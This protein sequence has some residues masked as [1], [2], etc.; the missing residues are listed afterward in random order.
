MNIKIEAGANVQITDKPIVNINGDL[1]YNEINIYSEANKQDA[2][3]MTS[4]EVKDVDEYGKQ[5]PPVVT[6]TP[7]EVF[8]AQVKRIMLLAEKKNDQKMVL[9]ARGNGG[10]YTFKVDGQGFCKVMDLLIKDY[11]P[12]IYEYLSGANAE[13]AGSIK[14][15]C[16]FIGFVLDTHLY[17]EPKL[18]KSDLKSV[19]EEVYGKGTS[20]TSKLST[21][22]DTNEAQNLFGIVKEIMKNAKKA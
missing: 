7:V 19:M 21:K 15:V 5:T 3:E 1:N 18:Q 4:E 6:K 2:A 17:S 12:Q 8:V 13:A 10:T 9:T 16:P 20:A 14:Y 11:T 22:Y